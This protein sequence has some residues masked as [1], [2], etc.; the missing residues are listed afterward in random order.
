MKKLVYITFMA[1]ALSFTSCIDN[2]DSGAA[3]CPVTVINTLPEAVGT[4]AEIVS[5]RVKFTELNTG[6]STTVA[7][8]QYSQ[9]LLPAGVYDVEATA[10]VQYAD[11]ASDN[12]TR[13]IR[14]TASSVVVNTTVDVPLSWYLYNP[15]NTLVFGE[16][17]FCGSLNATG[18]NGL[19]DSY[20]TIYN[21]T[22]QVLYADGLGIA[23]SAF[24]NARTNA[25]EILTEAN[26]RQVNFTAGTVWVIP[27]S[28]TDVPIQPGESIKIVDQ[29]IDWGAQVSGA[30]NHTDANFEWYDDNYQ[31]TDNPSVS[32]LDKWYCYSLSIWIVSNQCNR[33]YALIRFPEGMTKEEY[34]ADYYGKYDYIHTIGT[35]M[36]NEKA[37][38][39]PNDWI[40]D[41]VNLS[42]REA[43]V[44]GALGDAIDCSYA[45]ISDKNKDPERFGKKFRRKTATIDADGRVVLQDTDDSAAD[46]QLCAVKE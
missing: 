46:F 15:E 34:L 25:F 31:D 18:T 24:V 19:R 32:N 40:I 23:E 45:A 5:G 9:Y 2:E 38:L 27:G 7:L 37:Y 16:I 8:P 20:F 28:G 1:V 43:W 44:Y 39:V 12:I 35:H 29:A 41:G 42:N 33:S 21:N 26:N 22:D 11:A 13:S 36:T 3:Y 17:F 4:D 30:L 14:A 10:T 6:T